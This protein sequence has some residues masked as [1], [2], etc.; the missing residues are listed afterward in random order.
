[1]NTWSSL[2]Y[3]WSP[4]VPRPDVAEWADAHVR[5][6]VAAGGGVKVG[7]ERQGFEDGVRAFRAIVAAQRSKLNARTDRE[8]AKRTDALGQ[9]FARA[10]KA[11]RTATAAFPA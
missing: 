1:M 11:G 2:N 3:G 7:F 5:R 4:Y 8:L 10:P 9:L 6:I